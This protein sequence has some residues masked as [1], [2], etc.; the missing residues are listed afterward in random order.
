MLL[1]TR[2]VTGGS[3]HSPSGYCCTPLQSLFEGLKSLRI[4]PLDYEMNYNIDHINYV[5]HYYLS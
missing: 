1:N 2:V 3:S 5:T 4:E